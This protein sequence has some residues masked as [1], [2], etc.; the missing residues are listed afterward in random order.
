MRH[1]IVHWLAGSLG[2]LLAL[3][4]SSP[5]VEGGYTPPSHSGS[6]LGEVSTFVGDFG[7]WNA[8]LGNRPMQLL[9]MT[10]DEFKIDSAVW[11]FFVWMNGGSGDTQKELTQLS[12]LFTPPA[13]GKQGDS[14]SGTMA[15]GQ[16]KEGP[17]W[18]ASNQKDDPPGIGANNGKGSVLGGLLT[19]I[20]L[21]SPNTGGNTGQQSGTEQPSLS[22]GG[23]SGATPLAPDPAPEPASVTL[24]AV[25]GAGLLMGRWM[26]RKRPA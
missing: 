17:P 7:Q 23:N 16:L 4:L 26:R 12:S 22:N 3:V 15:W 13:P 5:V 20:T 25:G 11:L 1:N 24:L 8:S 6:L 9:Q 18:S 14:P 2:T 19:P 10:P 21:L